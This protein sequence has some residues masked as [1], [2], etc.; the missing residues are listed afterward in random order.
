MYIYIYTHEKKKVTF[1]TSYRLSSAMVFIGWVRCVSFLAYPRK[2]S[3]TFTERLPPRI[4][5]RMTS[6][7]HAPSMGFMS[8]IG[9]A[10]ARFPA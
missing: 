10:V 1:T 2:K 5:W 8:E 9:L 6:A 7:P 3:R 4:D